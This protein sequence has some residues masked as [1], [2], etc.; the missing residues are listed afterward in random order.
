MKMIGRTAPFVCNPYSMLFSD[1]HFAG[2]PA[3]FG[4]HINHCESARHPYF[5][6]C[7]VL[8]VKAVDV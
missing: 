1:V 3:L 6:H 5:S 4:Y 7:S 8:P 2:M